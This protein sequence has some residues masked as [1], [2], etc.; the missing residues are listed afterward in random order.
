[1]RQ[2]KFH[3]NWKILIIDVQTIELRNLCLLEY[4]NSTVFEA[5]NDRNHFY[6]PLPGSVAENGINKNRLEPCLD[7]MVGM[8]ENVKR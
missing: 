8:G 7:C 4:Y 6:P 2:D 5:K 3:K 1:M